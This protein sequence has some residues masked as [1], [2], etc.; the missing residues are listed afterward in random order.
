MDPRELP[1]ATAWTWY[2]HGA[3][4]TYAASL[5]TLGRMRNVHDFWCHV[6]HVPAVSNFAHAEI[7]C[8]GAAIRGYAVFRDGVT[9]EWEHA[10]N[11]VG[12]EFLLRVHDAAQLD[13]VWRDLLCACVGGAH[14]GAIVGVRCMRKHPQP[15]LEVWHAAGGAEGVR[16]LLDAQLARRVKVVA[17]KSHAALVAPQAA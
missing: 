15:K 3:A 7:R 17:H 14:G 6:H 8:G 10:V 2:A 11:A 13:D 16:A 5:V 4:S 12:G 9:P 1:L